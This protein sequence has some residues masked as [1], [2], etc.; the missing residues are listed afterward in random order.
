LTLQPALP[1]LLLLLVGNGLIPLALLGRV[2]LVFTLLF[3]FK[4]LFELT[5]LTQLLLESVLTE[6]RLDVSLFDKSGGST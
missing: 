4:L 1:L 5:E 3:V 6:L 2:T